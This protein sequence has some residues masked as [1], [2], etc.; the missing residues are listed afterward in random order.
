MVAFRASF[1]PFYIVSA[2]AAVRHR[3][4]AELPPLQG[5]SA[6][7][8]HQANMQLS[9][10]CT[11]AERQNRISPSNKIKDLLT[12]GT[13]QPQSE[14]LIVELKVPYADV[15]ICGHPDPEERK[16]LSKVRACACGAVPVLSFAVG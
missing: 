5:L 12:R 4:V 13:G 3:A 8:L 11:H 7:R 6:L 16:I 15:V 14:E 10:T 9:P 2:T 1:V